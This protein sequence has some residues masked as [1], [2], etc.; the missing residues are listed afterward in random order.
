[1]NNFDFGTP[2]SFGYTAQYL[3]QKC[4]TRR[5]WKDSHAAKFTNAFNKAIAE[6]KQLRV[7]AIDKGYHAG[8]KQIGWLLISDRPYKQ[9]LSDMPSHELK[10]EGGMCTTVAEFATKYFKG[11]SE[12]IVWVVRFKFQ[13]LESIETVLDA[14][15]DPVAAAIQNPS[16][17]KKCLQTLTSSKSDEHYTPKPIIDAAR[18]VMGRIDLDP[19]SCA[20]ANKTVRATK[21]YNKK[22][23]GLVQPWIGRVWLN[24]AFSL[25]DKAVE[26]L[27]VSYQVGVTTEALLLIKAAPD[28]KRH[29]SLAAF[30][31]CEWSGR[32]KF[33]A[34][35]NSQVA[36]FAVLIFYL[37]R[38]FLK[39]REVFSKFGNI[40][41]GQNQV[42]KLED[43][44]RELL[45]KVAELQLQLAKKSDAKFVDRRMDWLEDDICDRTE[46]AES[47]LK[48]FDIDYDIPRFEI[49]SRQRIEWT[50]KLEILKSLRKSIASINI[51]FFGDRQIERP[52]RSK[53]EDMEGWRSEFA[54][55]KLIQSGNLTAAIKR[56]NR[57]KGEWIA[58][59]ICQIREKGGEYK[60]IGKEFYITATELLKEFKPY[61]YEGIS[62][63]YRLG[64]IRTAQELK[65]LFG[66][67]KTPSSTTPGDE[68]QASDDSIWQAFKERNT[69]HCA[70][71]WRCE[72]LPNGNSISPRI[73]AQKNSCLQAAT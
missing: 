38:N 72:M 41:L 53:L 68:L 16:V 20:A 13:A 51:S 67:L 34:D 29:Q 73:S 43:D 33:I 46:E 4:V 63:P 47:R 24:P 65:K 15:A 19:M 3:P 27:L 59:A 9:K 21:F 31:Y 5:D 56:Y 35:G 48:A 60:E 11:D 18:E 23:D 62:L 52:P 2:I 26:K 61:K 40:R 37:G 54:I 14:E 49:L 6:G 58:I 57:I 8:G 44:R 25:A 50:A 36:P 42:D 1:M 17:A 70:I 71:K 45:T 32:I 12:K 7:P 55:G 64:S 28:T 10:A 39:F 69:G 30:P 66:D 22:A